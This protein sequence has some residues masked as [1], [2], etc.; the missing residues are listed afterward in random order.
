MIVLETT[1]LAADFVFLEGPRWHRGSLWVSDMFDR[2]VYRIDA[3]GARALVVAV[4]RRPSGIGFLP[5]GTPLIVSMTDRK[6]MKLVDGE[7]VRHADLAPYTANDINDMVVDD[8]GRAYVGTL[9]VEVFAGQHA[10]PGIL[11]VVDPAGRPRV[12]ADN[13]NIPNGTVI[14]DGG[15]TLV[16]AETLS[17]ILTAFDRR[18]DGTLSNRRVYAALGKVTPD[19]ICLDQ[20]GGIWVSSFQTG[21]FVRVLEGGEITARV[22]V[23]ER[24]AVAC[25]LG[26]D[27]G[28][29]LFCLT[30]EGR[31][32]DTVQDRRG[33]RIETVRVQVPGAGSP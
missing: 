12:A 16:V 29:T 13:M 14:K 5:D 25:Q 27:D 19:G 21:E 22:D 30:L 10:E 7:L 28:C 2:K 33:A 1:V 15:A 11:L 6:L 18:T 8:E 26:G 3:D 20:A 17:N 4:P 23:G 9:G 31:L 24:R 32:D